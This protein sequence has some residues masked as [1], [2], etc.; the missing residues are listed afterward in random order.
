MPED[1]HERVVSLERSR[2]R[3]KLLAVASWVGFA[4]L[5]VVAVVLGVEAWAAA[6]R[7]RVARR[8]AEAARS[9]AEQASERAKQAEDRAREV[10]Y[11]MNVG[12]AQREWEAAR[13]K[14]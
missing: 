7:D 1:L 14:P 2:R 3:W 6:D 13:T 10:L 5:I 12:L 8:E 9:E 4:L 11:F